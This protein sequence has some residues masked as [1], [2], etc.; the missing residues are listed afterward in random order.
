MRTSQ[1]SNRQRGRGRGG[2]KPGGGGG[3]NVVNRV[4][5]SAGPEGKVR[6]TPQQ[7]IE[8]YLALARDA[9]ISSDRVMSENFLQHAEHY[10]R[11]L[12]AAQGPQQQDRRENGEDGQGYGSDG[13]DDDYNDQPHGREQPAHQ[14]QQAREQQN[15]PPQPQQPQP[16]P[17]S[18]A[19]SSAGPAT[20][21][22][23]MIEP[24][25]IVEDSPL[26]ET[27]E[28]RS[29]RRA[30]GGQEAPA[31]APDTAAAPDGPSE[32]LAPSVAG[33]DDA[34]LPDRPKRRRRPRAADTAAEPAGGGD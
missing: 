14:P 30:N 11:M 1:K 26:V 6:G 21:G 10:Q 19:S 29:R 28:D 2:N 25:D 20:S 34:A 12:I 24:V 18:P 13:D 27:P 3:G 5:E 15:R 7:I 17:H 22:M 32:P 9:Q 31:P 8:K 23:D 33:G 4:F 16:H